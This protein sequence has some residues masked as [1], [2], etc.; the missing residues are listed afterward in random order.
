MR[1]ISGLFAILFAPP[2]GAQGLQQAAEEF[3][4]APIAVD[5]RLAARECPQGYRL[6][7]AGAARDAVAADCGGIR[8]TLP[9][10]QHRPAAPDQGLKR[11]D[12]VSAA[13]EG[14][15]FRIQLDAVADRVE[16]GGRLMLRNSRSGRAIAASLDANGRVRLGSAGESR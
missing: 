7:W 15:G 6:A 10:A 8:W 3:A 12:R 13:I 1:L 16:Q 11:G 14:D 9:L 5:A 4:A 2:A